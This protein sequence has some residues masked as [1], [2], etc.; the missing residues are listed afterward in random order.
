MSFWVNPYD[1]NTNQ[2]FVS[3]HTEAGGNIFLAGLYNGKEH[4]SLKGGTVDSDDVATIGYQHWV[5]N[6]SRVSQT[7]TRIRYIKDNVLVKD[8]V[9][10]KTMDNIKG[11][12]WLIGQEWDGDT[13]SDLTKGTIDEVA[14]FDHNLTWDEI[15]DINTNGVTVNKGKTVEYTYDQ[16][17][18]ITSKREITYDSETGEADADT[19]SYEYG[20]TNWKDKLTSYD[21]KT[22]TYDAIGNPLSYDGYSYTWQKGRQLSGI[23][24]NGINTSYK[25]N[26]DGIRTKKTVNGVTTTYHLEGDQVVYEESYDVSDPNTKFNGIYYIYTSDGSLVSMNL[27]GVEYYYIRNGQNDIIGLYDEVGTRVAS[28]TYDSWG[29]L[30]SIKNQNGNDIT[31]DKSSIGYKNPYRYRGYRYD[32]ETGL[33]YVG[34][35]YYDPEICRFINEDDVSVLSVSPMDLTDK[36]LFAYC[37]NNPVTRKDSTGAV[38]ET[39]FDVVSLGASIAEVCINPADPWA[40]AG[41]VGDTVDLIPFVTG[42]GEITRAVKTVNKVADTVQ[43]AK[44][45]DFTEDAADLVKSLDR[46]RGFTKSSASL[47]RKIHEGYK[48]GSDFVPDW[49]EYNKIK[50][51]C[52]D[53]IDFNT[54]TI[55]ELK[56]F[57]PK[58]VKSGIKQLNKYNKALGGRFIMRLELY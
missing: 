15:T 11:R 31:S 25:Y 28:Y 38:W 17:G 2:Y 45:V 9:V 44:A 19:I 27:D 47:G 37:D 34:S 35:R 4:L 23:S 3:K 33:F 42:V 36:N 20:D 24:G 1:A 7:Q 46:S 10:A 21:G 50:G 51:L 49:K 40:W 52:P 8:T 54:K 32:T 16:G 48:T 13:P 58:A 56:P 39:V 29:K 57:N 6:V 22:I 30:I 26:N 43:I 53:Y 5:I 55:F 14:F 18:N 41:L 12:P